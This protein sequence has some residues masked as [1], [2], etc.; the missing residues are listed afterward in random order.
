VLVVAQHG[1]RPADSVVG[2]ENQVARGEHVVESLAEQR[3]REPVATVLPVDVEPVCGRCPAAESQHLPEGVVEVLGRGQCHVVGYDVDDDAEA[4]LVRC[5][6]QP[7][8]RL[9]AAEVV[10]HAGVV[11][12]VVPVLRP[13]RRLQHRGEVQVRHSEVREVGDE[14]ARVV[15]AEAGVQLQPIR[16]GRWL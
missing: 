16:P 10:G 5:R 9:P 13:G 11:D 6:G 14:R 1:L 2:A 12:G 15:E 3:Q 8:E 7:L 4:V